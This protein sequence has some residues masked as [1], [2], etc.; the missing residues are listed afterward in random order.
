[1]RHSVGADRKGYATPGCSPH[2]WRL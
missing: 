1:M 2:R